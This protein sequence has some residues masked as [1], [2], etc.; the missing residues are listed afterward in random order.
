MERLI[1]KAEVLIEA[2]PYIRNF[3]NRIVVVKYGGSAMVDRERGRTILED[4]VFMNYVGIKVIVVHGGGYFINQSLKKE[5]RQP[6][7]FNGLRFTDEATIRVVISTLEELNREITEEIRGLGGEAI[8]LKGEEVFKVRPYDEKIGYVGEIK[9]VE[10]RKIKRSLEE[11]E[12]PVISPLGKEKEKIYNINADQAAAEV[13]LRVKAEKLV[14]LTDVLG[15]LA[16]KDKESSLISSLHIQEV[17]DLIK[18]EI[19]VGGMVPKV[20]S[21][22]RALENG[23]NKVHII[24]GR[25]KHSLLLEIFTDQGIGTEIVK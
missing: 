19:I 22:V 11:G 21:G 23:V 9:S 6:K 13:S 25:I 2:L 15:I 4:I 20:R 5:G 3:R 16:E 7:F 12:I 8:G 17:E 18:R 10:S 1:E 14:L 24:D